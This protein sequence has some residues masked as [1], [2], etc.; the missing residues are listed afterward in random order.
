MIELGVMI[1]INIGD[2]KN[3]CFLFSLMDD[4][5]EKLDSQKNVANLIKDYGSIWNVIISSIILAGL[6][7]S[8]F[9]PERAL[10][11]DWLIR[12]PCTETQI[13]YDESVLYPYIVAATLLQHYHA[14]LIPK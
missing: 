6:Y 7:S 12:L 13:A 1:L 10:H 3:R 8:K 9:A 14:R 4:C 5:R 2:V 11:H